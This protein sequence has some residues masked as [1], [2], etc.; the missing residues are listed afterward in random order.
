MIFILISVV[1]N[2]MSNILIDENI[3]THQFLI[4][5]ISHLL[6]A[7]PNP[8]ISMKLETIKEVFSGKECYEMVSRL[9]NLYNKFIDIIDAIDDTND[10]YESGSRSD[11]PRYRKKI[12]KRQK[13]L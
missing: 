13:T 9:Q 8:V 12:L 11:L 5:K 10:F 2:R 3:P 6:I 1:E 7:F 4:T